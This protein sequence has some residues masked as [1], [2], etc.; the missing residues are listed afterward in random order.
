[1]ARRLWPLEPVEQVTH[2]CGLDGLDLLGR[3]AAGGGLVAAAVPVGDP[4]VRSTVGGAR[5][6]GSEG[7]GRGLGTLVFGVR[8][9]LLEGATV[10]GVGGV[11]GAALS[12]DMDADA[13]V[14]A[15]LDESG[16]L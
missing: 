11:V 10:P 7:P 4:A 2:D 14:F 12:G 9:I 13:G 1:M 5:G 15:R 6:A 8:A 3:Q 16:P